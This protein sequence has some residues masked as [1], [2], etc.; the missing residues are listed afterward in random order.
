M[1]KGE[2]KEFV[3]RNPNLIKSVESGKTTWQKLYELYDLYGEENEALK[4]YLNNTTTNNNNNNSFNIGN[5]FKEFFNLVRGVDLNS[6]Q[7]GLNNLDKAIDAFKEIIPDKTGVVKD[8]YEP[9]P[10]YKYFED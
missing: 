1:S 6:V 2:F 4:K 7:K 3:K 10:T 9:R 8:L 5:N